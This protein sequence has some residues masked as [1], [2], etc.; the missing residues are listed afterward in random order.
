MISSDD[1]FKSVWEQKLI[2]SSM[3]VASAE[4]FFAAENLELVTAP[5][6]HAV[7]PSE[8]KIW[9]SYR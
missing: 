1:A 9:D 5:P 4:A 6:R 2:L 8:K 7:A 3:K